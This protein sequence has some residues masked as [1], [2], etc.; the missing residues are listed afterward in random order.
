MK[1]LLSTLLIAS[2]SL[3]LAQTKQDPPKPDRAIQEANRVEQS[4]IEVRIK[5]IARFRG[6]RANQ[7]VGYG[8]VIGLEGTG[9]KS[10]PFTQ[11]ALANIL[12]DFGNQVD[13]AKLKAKNVAAVMITAELPP[14]ASPGNRID[15]IVH[16][17]GDATSLQGGTL[18]QTPMFGA[19]DKENAYVVAMG[20]VSI[21]GFN[22]SASGNSVQK[23]HVNVGRIPGG[24]IVEQ[25]VPT[26]IVFD[27]KLFLEIDDADITTAHRLSET[28]QKRFP[29]FDPNPVDGGTIELRLPIGM[30]PVE[31]MSKIESATVFAD[32]PALVVVN[33]RTGTIVIGGNVRLGPAV[34]AHGSLQVTITRE[35]FVSQPNSFSNGT[36]VAGTN[37]TVSAEEETA[38][39]GLL[40]PNATVSDLARIF[41]TLQLS[42][43]DVISI[44]Q[45]LRDQGS[46]KARIKVQ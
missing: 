37:T 41:Q 27:G 29:E 9:D 10:I 13:A 28:L 19:G 21:G 40:G 1:T 31:A 20:P 44:L 15:V 7:L 5:D 32:I 18:L 2:V 17:I 16:S 46:L 6:V 26:Q 34:V 33:E 12:R 3:G 30:S 24:G 23:N 42:P 22:V 8:L 36:T 45:A 25:G 11:T 14:F 35:S 38:Q 4:G 39:V 43:R